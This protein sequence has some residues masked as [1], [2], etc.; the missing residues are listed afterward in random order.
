VE[1]RHGR[2]STRSCKICRVFQF[3]ACAR[4]TS[5]CISALSTALQRKSACA[6][7]ENG[8]PLHDCPPC[9]MSGQLSG[10][11]LLASLSESV[12]K[13]V[14]YRWEP[15]YFLTMK[16]LFNCTHTEAFVIT[17]LQEWYPNSGDP[18]SHAA[19]T[20]VC[21]PSELRPHHCWHGD[22]RAQA[23]SL[24]GRFRD[25]GHHSLAVF[26]STWGSQAGTCA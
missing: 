26:G 24:C 25:P 17:S 21:A 11:L 15:S 5:G 16:G 22:P 2:A 20:Q 23:H 7:L 10:S 18:P 19:P 4:I 3:R 14:T 1:W 8:A 13:T 12:L 6:K 9:S